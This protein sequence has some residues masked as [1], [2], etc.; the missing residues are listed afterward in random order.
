MAK[1]EYKNI[2]QITAS[3]SKKTAYTLEIQNPNNR[4][5]PL[6]LV[7]SNLSYVKIP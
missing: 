6:G 3:T 5:E 7:S 1:P 2:L 4:T